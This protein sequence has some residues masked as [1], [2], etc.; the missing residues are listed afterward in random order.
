MQKIY[1][2]NLHIILGLH[3][4]GKL[5]R[6][7]NLYR[8]KMDKEQGGREGGRGRKEGKKE[9]I[10]LKEDEGK[11]ISIKIGRKICTESLKK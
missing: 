6:Y 7:K 11:G 4:S 1:K 10:L 3:I 9:E 2:G 5:R 8:V